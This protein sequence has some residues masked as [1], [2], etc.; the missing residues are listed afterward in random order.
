M[1]KS[2]K[3]F[4]FS[5]DT[6]LITTQKKTFKP[7]FFSNTLLLSTLQEK[8]Q[9]FLYFLRTRFSPLTGR[10]GNLLCLYE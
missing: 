6:L 2:E 10:A 5:F 7:Q 4:H 9:F 1:I 3:S 8:K